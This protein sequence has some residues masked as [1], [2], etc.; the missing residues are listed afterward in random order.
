M[1]ILGKILVFLNLLFALAVAGFL[2]ID[3]QTRVNW[4]N[5]FE[6]LKR[7]YDVSE[8][9]FKQVSPTVSQTK[10]KI[11]TLEK[12]ITD[13]QKKHADAVADADKAVQREK[14]KTIE[15]LEIAKLSDLNRKKAEAHVATLNLEKV[16]LAKKLTKVE[17]LILALEEQKG[18]ADSMVQQAK[19]ERDV[20]L[21]RLGELQEQLKIVKLNEYKLQVS[22]TDGFKIKDKN[23]PN[24]P[25]FYIKGK[26]L[27]VDSE[28]STLVVLSL[29]K[30][31]GLEVGQ[32]LEIYR[33]I[34]QAK[35][36]GMV[37]I[38]ELTAHNAIARLVPTPYA[39]PVALHKDDEVASQILPG[40]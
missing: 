19:N 27:K 29:G 30:D 2:L 10:E 34:P 9:D 22:K 13:V 11:R 6:D 40:Y 7:Q 14:E 25:P 3:F 23:S 12:Q 17:D 8:T 20:L 15:A 5:K 32:T 16:E 24:P 39:P 18:K 21:N 31:Q 35:Y 4:K 37:R 33:K 28:D 36:L 1:N 26:V 38:Q